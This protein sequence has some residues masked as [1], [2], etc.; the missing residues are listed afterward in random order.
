MPSPRSLFATQLF[1]C[2][3]LL[4]YGYYL[5]Y[6][7]LL[8]PCPLCMV[9][10][11]CFFAVGSI[12]LVAVLHAP[13]RLFTRLYAAV[14]AL[15]TGA[16][17]MVAGRQ[18]WL[19]HSPDAQHLSCGAGLEVMLETLPFF[20][21]VSKVL[22][23]TGDCALVQWTLASLSIPEWAALCFAAM[24]LVDLYLLFKC[25]PVNLGAANSGKR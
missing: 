20:E 7:E 9:Q 6:V 13:G 18:I 5:Q 22:R 24:L 12:A 3:A 10:R 8:D 14:L 25:T 4:G 19:Q 16:G 11:L 2:T 17:A 23:G 1:A 15:F 21:V